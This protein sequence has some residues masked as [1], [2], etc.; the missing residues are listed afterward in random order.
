MNDYF[1]ILKILIKSEY[2]YQFYFES[3]FYKNV[4][5]INTNILYNG[6]N[7][8][9]NK[10]NKYFNDLFRAN[11]KLLELKKKRNIKIIKK[12]LEVENF[13]SSSIISWF[14]K[15]EEELRINTN[16]FKR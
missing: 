13:A 4:N 3:Q 7:L 11:I 1:N 15:Y 5:K 16:E 2:Y 6:I 14:R 9:S 12:Q 10:V 8:T